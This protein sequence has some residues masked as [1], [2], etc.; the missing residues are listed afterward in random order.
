MKFFFPQIEAEIDWERGYEFL[1][2]EFQQV[3]RE[4]ETGKAS[5]FIY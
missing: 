5:L 4:A 2:Q 3:V 1:D